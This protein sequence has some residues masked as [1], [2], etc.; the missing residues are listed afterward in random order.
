MTSAPDIRAL[1]PALRRWRALNRVKQTTVATELG[2]S[3][4]TISRWENLE[5]VPEPRDVRRLM[6]LIAATPTASSDLALI[7]LVSTAATPMH[8]VCDLTHRLIAAS[9]RRLASWRVGVGELV[10]TSLWRFASQG[11]RA[12]EEALAS[13]G[14]YEPVAPDVTVETERVSFPELTIDAGRIRYSRMPLANGGF[15]RLVRADVC[16]A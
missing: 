9:P 11:I 16:H 12:G 13:R 4:T 15:A 10:G 6:R 8:L 14:W 1:G 5:Q 7:E 2:V 3:Q